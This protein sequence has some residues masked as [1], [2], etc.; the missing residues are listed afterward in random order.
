[1]ECYESQG[2]KKIALNRSSEWKLT[3]GETGLLLIYSTLIN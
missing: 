3:S 1:M 2:D